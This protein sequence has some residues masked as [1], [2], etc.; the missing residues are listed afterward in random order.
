M[1]KANDLYDS[2]K[3]IFST[4]PDLGLTDL[5][6][7]EIKR[8]DVTLFKEPYRQIHLALFEEVPEH[9]KEILDAGAIRE[10]ESF[11]SSSVFWSTKNMVPI[12]F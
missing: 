8:V 7:H 6:E 4:G 5:V 3:D 11:F 12:F 9:L 1:H 10:S 2:W